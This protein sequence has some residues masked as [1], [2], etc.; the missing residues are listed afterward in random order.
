MK[1]TDPQAMQKLL[2][3]RQALE[4][5]SRSSEAKALMDLISK[6][7]NES[8]LQEIAQNA[9]KGDTAQLAAVIRTITST[10]GGAQLLQKLSKQM[11]TK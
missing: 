10:P 7:H 2:G 4:Q 9:A 6:G 5:L 8:S 1:P 11:E 3:N